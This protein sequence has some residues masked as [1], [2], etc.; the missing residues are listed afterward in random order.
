MERV[1][2]RDTFPLRDFITYRFKVEDA[3]TA[4]GQAMK[5]EEPM[6]IAITK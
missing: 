5:I 4:M 3:D 1:A 2:A 6:K